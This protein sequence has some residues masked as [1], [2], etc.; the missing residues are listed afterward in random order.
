MSK[1]PK[2]PPGDNV[3]GSVSS[4]VDRIEKLAEEKDSLAAD[5]RSIYAE[6]K[7]AGLD[8]KPLRILIARRRRDAAQMAELERIVALYEG[9][10]RKNQ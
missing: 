7:T 3:L 1:Q 10:M 8:P 9:A 5:I 6:A 2:Q 4:Y